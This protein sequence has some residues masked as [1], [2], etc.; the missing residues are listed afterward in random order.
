MKQWIVTKWRC[1]CAPICILHMSY[2]YCPLDIEI[3]F[4]KNDFV[5]HNLILC[6]TCCTH[7][8]IALMTQNVTCRLSLIPCDAVTGQQ[9][10]LALLKSPIHVHVFTSQFAYGFSDFPLTA[11]GPFIFLHRNYSIIIRYYYQ[12]EK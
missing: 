6:T 8:D 9:G 10:C 5:K 7:Y 12:E 2:L 3:F 4:F 11:K 1:A